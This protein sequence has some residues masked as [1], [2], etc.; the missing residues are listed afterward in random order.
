MEEAQRRSGPSLRVDLSGHVSSPGST[1]VGNA[2][3][4]ELP[5]GLGKRASRRWFLKLSGAAGLSVAAAYVLHNL[6]QTGVVSSESNVIITSAKGLIIADPTRCVGCR[7]CELACTEY[8]KGKSQPSISNIKIARNM[9]FGPKMASY[10]F[11]TAMGVFG[12]HRVVQDTCKQ[13]PHPVP[14]ATTC[15]YNAI[16]ADD[17]TGARV[18]DES[19]CVGCKFCQMACPWEMMSYDAE[20]KKAQKCH[21]CGGSPECAA[22]CPAGAIKYVPWTDMTKKVPP[23]VAITGLTKA[24]VAKDSCGSCHAG[25]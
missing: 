3:P 19:K 6:V 18:V 11:A 14:C 4:R 12:N 17:K 23:R 2:L 10:G 13:C 1:E 24:T 7:R 22:N 8:N 25:P 5:L 16:V 21:L 9:N 15:P 20:T